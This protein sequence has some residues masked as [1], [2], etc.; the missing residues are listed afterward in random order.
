[1]LCTLS[2]SLSLSHS[3]THRH[4][5]ATVLSLLSF[6]LWQKNRGSKPRTQVPISSQ[7]GSFPT[8][9]I[10]NNEWVWF[11]FSREKCIRPFTRSHWMCRDLWTVRTYRVMLAW[12]SL[13]I[14][15]PDSVGLPSSM[16][17]SSTLWPSSAALTVRI[18]YYCY[19]KFYS[20]FCF[21][22]IIF[23]IIFVPCFLCPFWATITNVGFFCASSL[24]C[25]L[26]LAVV[27]FFVK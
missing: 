20:Y 4:R 22:F 10:K 7:S 5:D 25:I 15:S 6:S 14:Q 8:R 12:F 26:F 2:L 21:L 1:M 24:G 16:R 23:L 13:R 3:H 9:K 11:S 18:N 27:I 17:G 19:Y